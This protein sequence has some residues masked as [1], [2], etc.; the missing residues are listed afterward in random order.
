MTIAGDTDFDEPDVIDSWAYSEADAAD[1]SKR[2]AWIVA[3]VAAGVALLEAVALVILLPLKT[4]EPY[5]LLVDKQTGYVEALAPLEQQTIA[6]DAALTRSFL[7]QYVIARESFDYDNLAQDYRKVALWSAG[8]A[9]ERY[10]ASIDNENGGG[11]LV[12][13]GANIKINVTVRSVSS[14]SAQS[15]LVRYSTTLEQGGTPAGPP[16]HWAAIINW[17][18]SGAE[19][20]A[21]DRLINPLGFQVT[22]YRTNTETLPEAYETTPPIDEARTLA[23]EPQ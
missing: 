17:Q 4:T 3:A 16:Q 1:R 6:A 23:K 9:R 5:T 12:Q 21:D 11:P 19:M 18:Y 22:R 8:P 10:I 14:L 20:T 13:Y 2:I 7:V 15:S